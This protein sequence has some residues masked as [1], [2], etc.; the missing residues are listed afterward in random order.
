MK[1]SISQIKLFKACRRA[2]FFKYV[3]ELEPVEKVEPLEIG[4]NYH[5]LIEK[6]YE[7]PDVECTQSFSK[8]QAMAV[9]Y[10]KYIYPQFKVKT[11]EE[12]FEYPILENQL[13]N[14]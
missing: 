4:S 1:V 2:Y 5:K 6:M 10:R 3:E 11:V 12:W 9:A 8:E 14:C 7:D 13:K